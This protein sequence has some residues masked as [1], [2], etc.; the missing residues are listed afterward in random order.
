MLH[1]ETMR[2]RLA[3]ACF[4]PLLLFLLGSCSR[5]KPI[6][7]GSKDS[8]EQRLL[9]E[10]VSQHLEHRLSVPIERRFGLGD[11]RTVHQSLLNG[12]ISMY[13]EY[14]GLVVSELLKETPN[15]DA[16]ITFER[17][18]LEMKRVELVEY[19]APLGFNANT[20]LA[21]RAA[22]NESISSA[23]DASSSPTRW[24]IG[25][26][27]EFQNR[28][29]GLPNLNTYRFEMGAP[30]KSMDYDD[31]FAALEG[32]MVSMVTATASDPHLLSPQWKPLTDDQHAFSPAEAALLVRDDALAAEPSLRGALNQLSGK[33]NL[34]TMR[35]LN[36]QVAIE[37][38][39]IPDVAAEFLK[40]A[41]L[42]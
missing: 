23:T 41:G 37:E 30:L 14:S 19:F 26:S 9:A 40:S 42:N 10:I 11:T 34:E 38:R 4:G 29:A 35:K 24:K 33:I 13:P 25:V 21:V 6:V 7:V 28:N 16:A 17:A 32:D 5:A 2:T 15:P 3:V 18:R 31:L 36:G 27:Y 39:K 12:E 20:V 8:V 22:G 1:V